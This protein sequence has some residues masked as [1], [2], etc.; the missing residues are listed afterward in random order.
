MEKKWPSIY[1]IHYM[2]NILLTSP[3]AQD[4]MAC[5]TDLFKALF[6]AGLKITPRKVQTRDPYSYLG[7]NLFPLAIKHQ[8]VQ[9][10]KDNLK[11]LNDFQKLL[12]DINWLR[13]YLKLT[14][15][16]LMLLFNILKG[17]AAP[18]SP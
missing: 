3:I 7:F 16:Q 6:Q 5:Y 14:T 18:T 12:G 11:T 13:P 2:D 1:I 17:D 4:V 15:G 10:R 9:I 8:K